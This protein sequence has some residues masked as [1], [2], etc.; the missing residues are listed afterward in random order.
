MRSS[1]SF[2]IQHLLF[3]ILLP[4][5]MLCATLAHAQSDLKQGWDNFAKNDI[6]RSREYF[7][8]AIANDKDKP[9]AYLMLAV[10]ATIDKTNEEAFANFEKF[11]ESAPDPI[12]YLDAL[13][14]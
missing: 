4:A 6:S 7:S 3:Y 13:L 14:T 11:Y 9:E 10:L 1:G 12:P 8:K 5:G 2:R